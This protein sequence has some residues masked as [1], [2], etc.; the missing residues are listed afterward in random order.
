MKVG[1]VGMGNMGQML[2]TAV[3]GTRL[4]RPG[5]ILASNRSKERLRR[6]THLLPEIRASCSNGE[7]A[8]E[9]SVL[10]LCVKP[11]E[12]R[13]VLEEI[14]PYITADHLLV[15]ITNTVEIAAL[16][17]ATPARVAKVIPSVVHWVG[18]GVSLLMFGS[19]CT[20]GDR[21]FLTRLM[22]GF[23]QPRVISESEARVASDL[24]SCGPAFLCYAFRALAQAAHRYAPELS[25][26]RVDEMV[27]LT[28]RATCRLL[29]EQRL[30]FDDVIDRVSTPGGVTADG[31]RVLDEQMA[32]VWEQVIET[33]VQ[34]EE[35]K[36]ARLE[37]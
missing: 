36:K 30:S 24:T 18:D 37:L 4:L 14:S 12:T 7:M 9:C 17:R 6:I 34:K 10:F 16:E 35:A 8:Q 22:G 21:E 31:I 28:A 19:R 26:G 1:F 23:S 15:T 27:R 11:G 3:A 20:E 32:G 29:E 13:A 2:V 33:T 5:E 25:Q